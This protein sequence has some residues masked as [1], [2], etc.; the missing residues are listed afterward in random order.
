MADDETEL[1]GWAVVAN[2]ARTTHQGPESEESSG[3]RHFSGG[4][5]VWVMPP[6][7]GDGGD[8]LMVIGKHRGH[9]GGFTRLVLPRRHLENFRVRAVYS[10]AV[11]AQMCRPWRDSEP[12]QWSSREEAEEHAA[13]WSLA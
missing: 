2:V 13:H 10:A 11:H 12:R 9:K 6:Q 3:T 4:T 1:L 5:K 8:S 7:W